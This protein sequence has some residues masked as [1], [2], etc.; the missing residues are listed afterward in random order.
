MRKSLS[1]TVK[2][3]LVL[4]FVAVTLTTRGQERKKFE[5]RTDF[6]YEFSFEEGS[7]GIFMVEPAIGWNLTDQ[8]F[9]GF[10]TGAYFSNGNTNVPVFG[11]MEFNFGSSGSLTPYIGIKCGIVFPHEDPV[12]RMRLSPAFGIKTRLS[13]RLDANFSIGYVRYQQPSYTVG[14]GKYKTTV[15]AGGSNGLSIN[16]GI[17]LHSLKQ[18]AYHTRQHRFA[19]F[20]KRGEYSAEIEYSTGGSLSETYGSHEY[21][22]DVKSAYGLR[23]SAL[24]HIWN[25]LYAGLSLGMGKCSFELTESYTSSKTGNTRTDEEKSSRC[26]YPLTVRLKYKVEQLQF[27]S[28]FLPYVQVDAGGRF[29]NNISFCVDP[30]F[31]LDPVVGL[32]YGLGNGGSV[33]FSIG[34]TRQLT[35]NY[36]LRLALGY[37]F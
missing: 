24:W 4:A 2:T 19:K 13:D 15:P 25:N 9:L 21:G 33:D 12:N 18:K 37:T 10:G 36:G 30:T 17:S 7:V 20:I 11:T 23:L 22:I 32:S 35:K 5:F 31:L 27:V 34:A 3:A 8:F 26:Y 29:S 28:G 1:F 14:S 6:G 16:A